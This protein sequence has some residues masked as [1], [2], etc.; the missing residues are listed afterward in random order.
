[1]ESGELGK[2]ITKPCAHQLGMQLE[3]LADPGPIICWSQQSQL[4]MN[5]RKHRHGQTR[6]ALS[7]PVLKNSDGDNKAIRPHLTID[8]S[9]GLLIHLPLL[10]FLPG[11]PIVGALAWR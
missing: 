9:D 3:Q 8:S 4:Y 2:H 7:C 6:C 5:I 1:M 10:Y 11:D